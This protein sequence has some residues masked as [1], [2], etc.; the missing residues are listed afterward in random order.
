MAAARTMAVASPACATREA[1]TG[2]RAN[3]AYHNLGSPAGTRPQQPPRVPPARQRRTAAGNAG[4]GGG[5]GV[6]VLARAPA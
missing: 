3:D 5:Q 2:P 6:P 4:G 1:R